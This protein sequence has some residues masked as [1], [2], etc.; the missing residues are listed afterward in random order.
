MNRWMDGWNEW[1]EE[2]WDM[3]FRF[4]YLS[5]QKVEKEREEVVGWI[6][7]WNGMGWEGKGEYE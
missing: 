3:R 5:E 7:G 1:M 6:I 2:R 4:Q